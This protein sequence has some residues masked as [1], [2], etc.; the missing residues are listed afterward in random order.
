MEDLL[1]D[2]PVIASVKDD[3]GLDAALR[4]EC[5]VVFLLYGSVLTVSSLVERL[6]DAGKTVLVNVDLVEGFVAKEIVVQF[7]REKTGA[8]GILSSKAALVKAARA[9]GLL[10]VHRLFLVDSFSYHNLG[11]QIAISKPDYVEILP[12]CVPRVI[13][14]L[15]ADIDVPIIAGGLVCDKD[16]VVAALGAGAAAIA[17]S[18]TDVWAM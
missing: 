16:D 6:K 8:D 3:A 5:P 4:S 9:H 10:G 17:S 7:V 14:W 1:L 2:N 18:N 11:R 12:G 13:T 15:R